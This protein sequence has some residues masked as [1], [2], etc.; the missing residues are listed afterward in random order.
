M[1][2]RG[3]RRLVCLPLA[4]RG[5]LR[6]QW[7]TLVYSAAARMLSQPWTAALPSASLAVLNH[8]GSHF[9]PLSGSRV[10]RST[11]GSVP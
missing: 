8:P 6:S 4:P 11:I 1:T 10:R 7:L 5:T 3:G 2:R 9:L